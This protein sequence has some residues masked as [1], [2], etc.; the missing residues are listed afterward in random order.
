MLFLMRLHQNVP[1]RGGI[2]VTRKILGSLVGLVTLFLV[3]MTLLFLTKTFGGDDRQ[4][5]PKNPIKDT[6]FLLPSSVQKIT[7]TSKGKQY[8]IGYRIITDKYILVSTKIV[9]SK[10][11]ERTF[12]SPGLVPKGII[13]SFGDLANDVEYYFKYKMDDSSL[14]KRK[15]MDIYGDLLLEKDGNT[16]LFFGGKQAILLFNA[17]FDGQHYE[18]NRR[19]SANR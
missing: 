8:I 12:F 13:S 19:P 5:E 16:P 10:N 9:L 18:I 11:E 15:P 7:R 6:V 3:V 4:P 17:N 2:S 1:N 14:D